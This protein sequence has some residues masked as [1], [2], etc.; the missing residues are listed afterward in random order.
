MKTIVT[1]G[2]G[3]IG[4]HLVDKLISWGYEVIV[5]DNLSNGKKENLNK[6][7]KFVEGDI[8]DA[9][10]CKDNIKDVDVVFHLAAEVDVRKGPEEPNLD[11]KENIVGTHNI[12]EAMRINNVKKVVFTS[13][14]VVYGEATVMPTPEDYGPLVPI[15]LYAASKL[16]DEAMICAYC[17]TFDMRAWIY[18]FANVIG[19]RESHGILF[20]FIKKLRADPENLEILGDGSQTKSYIHVGDCT[21]AIL[22]GLDKGNDKVNIYNIGSDDYVDVKKIAE[23]VSKQMNLA[24]NFNFTGG[25]KGWVGDVRHMQLDAKKLKDIGWSPQFNSESAIVETLKSLLEEN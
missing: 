12:L 3:F 4:S 1:G 11:F 7:A 22:V 16:S 5:V 15:S 24:P 23:L 19:S 25:D 10:F 8:K 2:A 20:D 14:S 6:K 18:R 13:S 17:N 9:E 21:D